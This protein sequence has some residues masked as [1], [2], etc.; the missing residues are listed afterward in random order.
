MSMAWSADICRIVFG[1]YI[2]MSRA[3]CKN[4]IEMK[5]SK[6]SQN[7]KLYNVEWTVI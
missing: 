6:L 7:H 2:L 5:Y 1:V 4:T 3:L